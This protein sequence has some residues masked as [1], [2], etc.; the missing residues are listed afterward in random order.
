MVQAAKIAEVE[1]RDNAGSREGVVKS[2]YLAVGKPGS[3]NNYAAFTTD[4]EAWSTPRHKHNFDQIRYVIEG[5]GIYGDYMRHPAGQVLYAPEGVAYGP[6]T[7]EPGTKQF[8][9]QFGGSTGA[10]YVS[11]EQRRGAMAELKKKGSFA[12][13]IYT[14]VDANG[15]RH[16]QDGFEAAW[17]HVT[18]Q[19]VKYPQPRYSEM[20]LMD[21]ANFPWAEQKGTGLAYKWMGSFTERGTRLGF[22]RIDRGAVLNVGLHPS[23]QVLFLTKGKVKRDSE[24]Y[25]LHSAFGIDAMEGRVAIEAIEPSEF[26]CLQM[27][28]F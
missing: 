25:P 22:I 13:G 20:I 26:L 10:G 4:T 2:R 3:P 1:A 12:D 11:G 28:Q 6:Q 21:P 17:E 8:T 7:R 9:V 24:T 5:A 15:R 16:N 14:Y 18:G 23:P 27:P 19:P